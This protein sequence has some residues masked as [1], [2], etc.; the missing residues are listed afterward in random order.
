MEDNKFRYGHQSLPDD[1]ESF[2]E[3]DLYS[4]STYK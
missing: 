1:S 4:D 3:S 2:S